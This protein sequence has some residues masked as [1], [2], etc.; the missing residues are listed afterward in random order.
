MRATQKAAV[1]LNQDDFM[2]KNLQQRLDLADPQTQQLIMEFSK[3]AVMLPRAV[4][5][6]E[7][8]RTACDVLI[9]LMNLGL[10]DNLPSTDEFLDEQKIS[11]DLLLKMRCEPI[12]RKLRRAVQTGNPLE[13]ETVLKDILLYHLFPPERKDNTL[14]MRLH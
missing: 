1:L 4:F 11:K 8:V 14:G 5:R 13:V 9:C 6:L 12:Q 3:L 2:R 10:K 7:G